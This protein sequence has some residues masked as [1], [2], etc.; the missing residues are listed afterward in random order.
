VKESAIPTCRGDHEE[1]KS[2]LLDRYDPAGS[3]LGDILRIQPLYR[4]DVKERHRF[5]PAVRWVDD[6]HD[7][8]AIANSGYSLQLTYLWLSPKVILDANVVY[9]VRE[10]KAIN[11]IYG[12]VVDA[13]RRAASLTAFRPEPLTRVALNCKE[14]S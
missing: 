13:D 7:G 9:G 1:H 14:S 4:V 10:G 8:A 2:D 3:R 12:K 6:D 5:E 11:P